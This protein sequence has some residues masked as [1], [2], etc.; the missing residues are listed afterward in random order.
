MHENEEEEKIEWKC[1]EENQQKGQHLIVYR[2]INWN[3]EAAAAQKVQA[4]QSVLKST[5]LHSFTVAS[6]LFISFSCVLHKLVIMCERGLYRKIFSRIGENQYVYVAQH[7]AH[8]FYTAF[9]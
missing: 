6:F 9:G 2:M 8:T 3:E 5:I 4:E 7:T 1:D